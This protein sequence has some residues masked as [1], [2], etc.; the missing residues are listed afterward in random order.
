MDAVAD[1]EKQEAKNIVQQAQRDFPELPVPT[2]ERLIED[3]KPYPAVGVVILLSET[4]V[5]VSRIYGID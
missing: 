3:I 2:G 1:R 4:R 5:G